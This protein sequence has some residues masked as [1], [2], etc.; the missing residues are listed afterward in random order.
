MLI[1]DT[2]GL[3]TAAGEVDASAAALADV[4]VAGPFADASDALVG[5][6]TSQGCLWVSTRLAAAVQ[7]YAE[8]LGSL[9]D[10]SRV[11]ARDLTG[12]DADVAGGFGTA[13]R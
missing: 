3:T 12:T 2:G 9:A 11:T 7:V 4:D 8:G 13:P 6:R 1:A 5:S 10:A